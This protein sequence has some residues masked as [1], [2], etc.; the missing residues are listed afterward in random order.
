MASS[1]FL[2]GVS[3][4]LG[5]HVLAFV[6]MSH[7]RASVKPAA[8]PVVIE[9]DT[10]PPPP[11]P[12]PPE[13]APLEPASAEPA[14]AP[15]R[16]ARAAP[17]SAAPP[18]EAGK[19]LAAAADAPG[20]ADFTMVQGAGAT[21]VGGITTSTGTSRTEGGAHVAAAAAPFGGGGGGGGA[22]RGGPDRSRKARP[23]GSDWDCSSLFPAGATTDNATVVIVA[24]VREG[25]QPESVNVVSDPGQGF[26]AAARACAMRQ[27]YAAAEDQDGRPVVGMTA[28]FRVRFTR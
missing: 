7:A 8:P 20:V 15:A 10:A 13:P 1:R 4:S 18:A 26:G 21:Y 22:G 14:A 23:V 12:P 5:V 16:A 6:H 19:V 2:L 24:R 3:A 17:A 28:P 25:G 9:V 27:R 11:A